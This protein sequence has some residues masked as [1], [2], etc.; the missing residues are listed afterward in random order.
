[1]RRLLSALTLVVCLIPLAAHSQPTPQSWFFAVLA[2]PQFG[3]YTHDQNFTQ[4]TSNF[5]FV[6]TNLNRLHP[7]FVV[8]LGDFV[9]RTGSPAEIAEYKRIVKQLDPS[10]PVYNVAGNHDVGNVPSPSH[11]AAYRASFGWDYYSFERN[12][13]FGIVLDSSLIGVPQGYTAGSNAQL[14]W[15]KKT[16]ASPAAQAAEQVVVFQHI[17]YFMHQSDEADSYYNLP[18]SVRGT[19]LDLLSNFGVEWVFSGHLHNLAGGP[20]G[21]LTQWITGA[22]GMPIG[23]AG[24]GITLVAVNGRQLQPVWYC[25]AGLPNTFDPTS[26][27]RSACSH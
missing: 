27:P 3:M 11:I 1:M 4:E 26:P 16:L 22:V 24:S 17:P 18:T 12:G 15:L 5:E 6:V 21:N 20:W 2:D 19:Y 13:L 23:R 8:V 9:N 7:A 10:I 25:L 14:S